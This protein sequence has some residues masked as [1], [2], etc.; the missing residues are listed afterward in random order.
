MQSI[1]KILI[2]RFSSMGDIVLASPFVRVLRKKYPQAQIDF[3]TKEEFSDLVNYDPNL[4]SVITLKSGLREELNSLAAA[5]RRTKYDILFDL[6]NSLRSRFLRKLV[7][8][9]ETRIINKRVVPRFFLVNFK[10]NFYRGIVPVSE[11][12]LETAKSFGIANDGKGTD[13]FFP[14]DIQA[15]A[16]K[17]VDPFLGGS[18]RAIGLCPAAK[19]ATKIWQADKYVDLGCRITSEY[20]VKILIFGGQND[21]QYCEDIG[22]KINAN[23]RRNVALNCAGKFSILETAAA[24]DRCALVV[25][26]DSGIMHIASA[27]GK[28]IIAIFG[29]TVEEFGFFPDR[30]NGIV[31]EN[32]SLGCR[33]CSHIGLEQC[34]KGHFKCMT[35]I[36]VN[37]VLSA[38]RALLPDTASANVAGK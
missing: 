35:E 2:I 33:P 4:T 16:F 8:A 14:P 21:V 31:I 15:S 7:N 12:Y 23:T 6:H 26:N 11:R 18:E 37:D 30:R 38:V 17:I 19:H 29:P 9:G 22:S 3:L 5:L 32:K 36:P 28:K 27:R 10:W 13:I 34:P 25:T 1:S 20:G 24:I